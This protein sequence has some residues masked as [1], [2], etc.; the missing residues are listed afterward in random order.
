MLPY[1]IEL[2][3]IPCHNPPEITREITPRLRKLVHREPGL[4]LLDRA[5]VAF[6]SA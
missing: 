4:M 6:T 2:S 5:Y 1:I 3:P